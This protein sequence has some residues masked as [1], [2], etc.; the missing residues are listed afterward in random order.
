LRANF[1]TPNGNGL[2]SPIVCL[3]SSTLSQPVVQTETRRS[4][5]ANPVNP[6]CYAMRRERERAR[7][8]GVERSERREEEERFVSPSLRSSAHSK[9]MVNS[10]GAKSGAGLFPTSTLVTCTRAIVL[11]KTRTKKR[12]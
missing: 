1:E 2:F 3:F 11:K 6:P 4:G 10:R 12:G 5:I 9:L 8:G 7:A